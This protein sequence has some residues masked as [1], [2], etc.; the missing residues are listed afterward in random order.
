M[1]G[2]LLEKLVTKAN[3]AYAKNKQALILKI[4]VPIEVTKSG[5]INKPSTVDFTGLLSG[6]RF[7]AFDAKETKIKTSFPLSN[8]HEHQLQYLL[9]VE[10]LGGLAFF[11]I[12][13]TS[14][15]T[16]EAFVVPASFVQ[17]YWDNWVDESGRASIPYADFSQSW[18]KPILN[19][20]D[21]FYTPEQS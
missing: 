9:R 11:L 1:R 14:L 8:I 2:K 3:T 12:H 7:I 21:D 19:Y 5:L 17:T 4:P 10:E 13:F 6:G 16:E 18:L 20:L 15:H